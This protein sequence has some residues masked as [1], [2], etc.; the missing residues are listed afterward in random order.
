MKKHNDPIVIDEILLSGTIPGM[1]ISAKSLIILDDN[2]SKANQ[3]TY[4]A[5]SAISIA[6]IV[7]HSAELLLKYKIQS[8]GKVVK[9][10][11]N[12]YRYF[13]IL[14]A[15]SISEIEKIFKNE[16][17][18]DILRP[19]LTDVK[20]IFIDHQNAFNEW[21]YDFATHE[22]PRDP[23]RIVGICPAL[24]YNATLSVYRSTDIYP[25]G[26]NIFSLGSH[27]HSRRLSF[28]SKL[29]S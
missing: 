13:D 23:D 25:T 3:H 6:M 5:G 2:N 15:K 14:E 27:L 18:Q 17:P 10:G 26:S 24:L 11:H 22:G 29:P 12:L 21:R 16:T 28:G 4:H 1:L 8:E 7:C 9:K 20:S 19:G